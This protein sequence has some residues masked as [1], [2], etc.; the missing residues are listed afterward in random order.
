M[1]LIQGSCHP[2]KGDHDAVSE[3]G[4]DGFCD[5]KAVVFIEAATRE[6]ANEFKA[7]THGAAY[8][9]KADVCDCDAN[10]SIVCTDPGEVIK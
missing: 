7:R 5:A 9:D 2:Q 6:G 1:I 10:M 4:F 8:T 3:P